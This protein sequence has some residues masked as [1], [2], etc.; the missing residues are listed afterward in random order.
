MRRP[1]DLNQALCNAIKIAEVNDLVAIAMLQS[2]A[3]ALHSPK[4][5]NGLLYATTRIKNM[6]EKR[7]PK[8]KT[9]VRKTSVASC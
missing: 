9:R 5:R 1:K 2:F 8:K 6:I 3:G 7:Q 4:D